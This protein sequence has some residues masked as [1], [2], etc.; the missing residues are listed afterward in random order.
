MR[1][2]GTNLGR[3]GY[4]ET[5]NRSG[6]RAGPATW[7]SAAVP[8]TDA[9]GV[10]YTV[11]ALVQGFPGRATH[12]GALGWSGIT[13]LGGDGRVVLVDTGGFGLR[14]PLAQALADRG[15]TPGD[16]P[17]VLLTHVHYDHAVNALLFPHAAVW[18]SAVDLEWARDRP[19]GFD[20]VPELYAAALDRDPRTRRIGADGPVLPGV[21]AIAA[22]GHTPGS[23]VYR[24]ATADG[25]E[26]LFAGDAVKNRAELLSGEVD[27]TEDRAASEASV[28]LVRDLFEATPGTVL[29]PG[30]DLPMRVGPDGPEYLG[31][32]AAGVEAWF[33]E[34][35]A[36]MTRFDIEERR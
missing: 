27:L 34:D 2:G 32:R 17:D 28:R 16:V 18:I 36:D 22:P 31:R 21:E 3:W 13:L 9:D 14:A 11:D 7:K 35:L 26:V 29:V 1:G 25:P 24:V 10:R 30:H 20:P 15:V 6:P 19:P 5:R 33:G 23:V 4:P 12:H 8:S